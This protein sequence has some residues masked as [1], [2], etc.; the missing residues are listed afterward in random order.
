MNVSNKKIYVVTLGT[1]TPPGVLSFGI[2]K[3]VYIVADNL[4]KC[5]KI[6]EEYILTLKPEVLSYDGSINSEK[7]IQVKNISTLSEE[8]I[9]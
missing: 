4:E 9:Y 3:Y 8:V 6:A 5:A 2:D 1:P 7:S